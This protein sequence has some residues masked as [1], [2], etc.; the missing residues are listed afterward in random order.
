MKT[1]LEIADEMTSKKTLP[2]T[3]CRYCTSHCPKHIDIPHIIFIM[4]MSLQKGGFLAPMA[5]SA[6][7]A[8]QQP[9]A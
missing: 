5:L 6:I 7:P 4:S 1:L 3:G 2:C 9:S 8:D